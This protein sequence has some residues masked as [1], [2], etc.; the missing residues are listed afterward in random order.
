MRAKI[1]VVA[2][3]ALL[4]AQKSVAQ[5]YPATLLT[6][7]SVY[8]Y[9]YIQGSLNNEGEVVLEGTPNFNDG[10]VV[11]LPQ[12]DHSYSA[13][14]TSISD[15]NGW[16]GGIGWIG[17]STNDHLDVIGG[18]DSASVNQPENGYVVAQFGDSFAGYSAGFYSL[19]GPTTPIAIG[20]NNLHQVIF[21]QDWSWEIWL[22]SSDYG[23]QVG[24]TILSENGVASAINN[25]GEIVGG[26]YGSNPT[27]GP[28][29]QAEIWLPSA[30]FGLSQG[31]HKIG[32]TGSFAQALNDNGQVA[33]NL[34][35]QTNSPT[36]AIWLPSA[37][38]GLS[39]G[40]N[41]IGP[42]DSKVVAINIEGQVVGTYS[43]NGVTHGFLWDPVAGFED[44]NSLINPAFGITVI[45]VQSI[46]NSSEILATG[47]YPGGQ[48][49]FLLSLPEPA[50]TFMPLAGMAVFARQRRRIPDK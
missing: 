29:N 26:A 31:F 28:G 44:L 21:T 6:S 45:G 14:F 9:T 39:A 30:E 42:A 11:W 27:L 17:N 35:F 37:A 33:V 8:A 24:H 4:A 49:V 16:S 10:T 3:T 50:T 15:P 38:F 32:P 46:N 13:G 43:D 1:F 47:A 18:L 36:A 20:I 22:P 48:A 25:S 19:F 12:A 5:Y 40:L 34:N 7:S 2:M 23:L 41:T